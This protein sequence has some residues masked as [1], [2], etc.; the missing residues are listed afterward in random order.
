M[1]GK[2]LQGLYEWAEFAAVPVTAQRAD[3]VINS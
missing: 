2:L 3:A 1:R